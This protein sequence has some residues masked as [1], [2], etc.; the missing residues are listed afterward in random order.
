MDGKMVD[1]TTERQR[2]IDPHVDD[3]DHCH[4]H[5]EVPKK[6]EDWPTLT[7]IL[8]FRDH[9]RAHLFKLYEDFK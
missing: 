3:P 8:Y 5:S 2:G 4:S 6:D 7:T 1:R 9:V